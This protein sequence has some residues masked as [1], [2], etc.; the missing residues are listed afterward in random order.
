MEKGATAVFFREEEKKLKP[1]EN[2]KISAFF[3]TAGEAPQIF[4]SMRRLILPQPEIMQI[5]FLLWEVLVIIPN[6]KYDNAVTMM[7]KGEYEAAIEV[8]DELGDYKNS[9]EKKKKHRKQ[10]QKKEEERKASI[11][12]KAE[13]LFENEQYGEA[14][15][16]YI[17]LADYKN[18]SE[19]V[20]TIKSIFDK[21]YSDYLVSAYTAAEQD[22]CSAGEYLDKIPDSYSP[23]NTLRELYQRYSPYSGVFD[24]NREEIR[25]VFIVSND[26]IVKW[27]ALK[28]DN[29]FHVFSI[30]TM[31][32]S[33]WIEVK[34]MNVAVQ[35]KDDRGKTIT[36]SVYF[37]NNNIQ[38][39]TTNTLKTDGSTLSYTAV[40]KR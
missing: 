3:S 39:T 18:S 17:N 32:V 10:V 33:D 25:S 14:L 38:I 26:N 8:F 21:Q 20:E 22:I 34:G 2:S 4:L 11:Y 1:I 35:F 5:P 40:P 15:P 6:N 29:S 23:A 9:A 13:T 36:T 37:I 24:L 28:T 16:L 30:D 7:E 19:R 12:S 31:G 27:H